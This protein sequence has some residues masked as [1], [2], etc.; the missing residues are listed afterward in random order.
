MSVRRRDSFT[1]FSSMTNRS[2]GNTRLCRDG[3]N[4]SRTLG[5]A[6]AR[7]LVVLLTS[8]SEPITVNCTVQ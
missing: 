2:S 5:A 7:A 4:I 3:A 1:T 8:L 6:A